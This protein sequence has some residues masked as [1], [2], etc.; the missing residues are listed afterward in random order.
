MEDVIMIGKTLQDILDEKNTNVNEL[1]KLINVSNQTLYSII[2]RDNMKVDL[3]VL[4]KI[5]NA[6]DVNIERFYSDYISSNGN[7]LSTQDE[8]ALKLKFNSLNKEKQQELL[9][10][11][12]YLSRQ[13]N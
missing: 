6:L 13:D 8:N 1:S 11:L 9:N 3:D 4:I 12:D 5:C 10:Y 2:K 7:Q